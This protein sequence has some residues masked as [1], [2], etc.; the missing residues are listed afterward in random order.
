MLCGVWVSGF[1]EWDLGFRVWGV[2]F[3]VVDQMSYWSTCAVELRS[4]LLFDDPPCKW[5]VE[6]IDSDLDDLPS[7]PV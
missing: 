4:S 6:P 5:D 3:G 2:G 7:K 1:G